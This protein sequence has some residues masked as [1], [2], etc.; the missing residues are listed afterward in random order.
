MDV[1]ILNK[2]CRE[3][4]II[5]YFILEPAKIAASSSRYFIRKLS[6]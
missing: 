2:E 6:R 4:Q 1:R 3:H 5:I